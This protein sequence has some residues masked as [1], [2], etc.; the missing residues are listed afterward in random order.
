[1]SQT[2]Q[3]QQ[4][5]QPNQSPTPNYIPLAVYT[6]Y[7]LQ[8]AFT[9]PEQL[10]S[11]CKELGITQVA[12][13]DIN[14]VS[15]VIKAYKA[16]S[17]AGVK[18]IYGIHYKKGEHNFIVLARNPDGWQELLSIGNY[19]VLADR[20]YTNVTA[21]VNINDEASTSY[22]DLRLK[23]RA[24]HQSLPNLFYGC[25]DKSTCKDLY[26]KVVNSGKTVIPL[27][28]VYY[29]RPEDSN[30]LQIMMCALHKATLK[31]YE[32]KMQSEHLRFFSNQKFHLK[33]YEEML[34]F[35][36]TGTELAATVDLGSEHDS[37]SLAR[38][39]SL[40][41]FSEDENGDLRNLCRAGWKKLV[42]PLFHKPS[43]KLY[44]EYVDRVKY[45]LGVLE[46]VGF[47]GYFLI[48]HDYVNAARQRGDMIGFARGSGG[49]CIVSYLIG[50]TQIDPV[51]YKL[52]FSRFINKGRLSADN[53]SFPD[54]DIDFPQATRK[55]TIEYIRDKY[56][57][58]HV[59]QICTFSS[60]QGRS[61]L[62]EVLR[63]KGE[64][65]QGQI[66][67][68]TEFVPDKAKLSDVLEEIAREGGVASTIL[69]A[70]EH[71]PEKFNDWCKLKEDGSLEGELAEDFGIAIELEG[72][73]KSYSKHASGLIISPVPLDTICIM[74]A[75]KK[76]KDEKISS[77]EMKDLEFSGLVKFDILGTAVLDKIMLCRK[78]VQFGDVED[79][80][81]DIEIDVEGED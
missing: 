79:E 75:D 11:R 7:S 76:N 57:R 50:N 30:K 12:V 68:I 80:D 28:D 25:I 44:E 60:L 58:D 63:I 14:S 78:L 37:F 39:P 73:Y 42:A 24:L 1:M 65:D 20:K 74:T 59:C 10:A 26:E 56:G 81:V 33:S 54:L 21:I 13:T 8:R 19:G 16:L 15:G 72:T 35:G 67:S 66:N 51:E 9:K 70:L 31:N 38:K 29:A 48:T 22:E 49:G 34:E 69:W 18:L 52:P 3:S 27:T 46:E 61:A 47:S 23:M 77:F 55:K 64:L 41:K 43:G 4:V 62:R 17:K 40:P 45:E 5:T 32:S 6:H 71:T 36:F 53:F 2:N